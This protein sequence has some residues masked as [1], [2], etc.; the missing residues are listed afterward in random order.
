M[1]TFLND[2]YH[3]Y[4]HHDLPKP[5][6]WR[7]RSDYDALYARLSEEGREQLYGVYRAARAESLR[8]SERAF[9][10]GLDFALSLLIG[11]YAEQ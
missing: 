3:Q 10:A 11:V 2:L 6:D 9:Q 1:N 7:A 4:A 8:V 5:Q